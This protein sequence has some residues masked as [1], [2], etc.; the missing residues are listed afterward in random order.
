M[1]RCKIKSP[2]FKDGKVYKWKVQSGIFD[3]NTLIFRP[4]GFLSFLFGYDVYF[5]NMDDFYSALIKKYD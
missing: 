1:I 2:E 3:E 4:D 5:Q